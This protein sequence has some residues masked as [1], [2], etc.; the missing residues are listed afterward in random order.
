MSTEVRRGSATESEERKFECKYR[1]FQDFLIMDFVAFVDKGWWE[2]HRFPAYG[3]VF[4]SIPY[5]F[6]VL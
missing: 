3:M 2:I 4:E 5:I 6:F 1:V